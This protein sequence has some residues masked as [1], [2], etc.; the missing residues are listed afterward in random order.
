[1]AKLTAPTS[2]TI[3]KLCVDPASLSVSNPGPTISWSGTT[4]SDIDHYNFYIKDGNSYK[5]IGNCIT[6]NTSDSTTMYALSIQRDTNF[7]TYININNYNSTFD[8]YMRAIVEE[9]A[10]NPNSSDMSTV[11]VT[12]RVNEKPSIELYQI[13][14][15]PQS[16][17]APAT[18]AHNKQATNSSCLGYYAG[19]YPIFKINK[20]G[21]IKG[22]FE[23]DLSAY[24]TEFL[25]PT[26]GMETYNIDDLKITTL[27][28]GGIVD[29]SSVG[30]SANAALK[31]ILYDP[32]ISNK[33][34]DIKWRFRVRLYDGYEYSDNN[35]YWP[36]GDATGEN[37]WCCIPTYPQVADMQGIYNQHDDTQVSGTADKQIFRQVRIKFYKDTTIHK[38]ANVIAKIGSQRYN[39]NFD[40]NAGTT[41]LGGVSYIDIT[42]P[43]TVTLSG[44]E[45][46]SFIIQTQNSTQTV[47]KQFTVSGFTEVQTP[48]TPSVSLNKSEVRPFISADNAQN[49]TVTSTSC[50]DSSHTAANCAISF[51]ASGTSGV[52]ICI[53]TKN[54]NFTNEKVLGYYF[55][56]SWVKSFTPL[57]NL[58]SNILNFSKY[59]GIKNT[60]VYVRITNAFGTIIRSTPM[61]LALK[62][63]EFPTFGLNVDY[64]TSS[65][66]TYQTFSNSINANYYAQEGLYLNFKPQLTFSP[67]EKVKIKVGYWFGDDES[68]KQ[69]YIDG[70]GNSEFITT[71][72]NGWS[73]TPTS[74]LSTS[75]STFS[76]VFNYNRGSTQGVAI[77]PLATTSSL[78]WKVEATLDD[79][80]SQNYTVTASP[81]RQVA[82]TINFVNCEV[83][84]ESTIG[85]NFTVSDSG[86]DNTEGAIEYRLAYMDGDSEIT[87]STTITPPSG[88]ATF[89]SVFDWGEKPVYVQSVSYFSTG[90]SKIII[91]GDNSEKTYISSTLDVF[92]IEP[93]LAIRE[94]KLGVNVVPATNAIADLKAYGNDINHVY[95]RNATDSIIVDVN[96]A[97]PAITLPIYEKTETPTSDWTGYRGSTQLPTFRRMGNLVIFDW[98]CSPTSSGQINNSTV[99]SIPP[100]FTPVDNI[101]STGQGSNNGIFMQRANT[102][103]TIVVGRFRDF[104][105]TA[106]TSYISVP[107]NYWVPIHLVY[108]TTDAYPTNI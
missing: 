5:Y 70:S 101:A 11:S 107:T 69:Y 8:I 26:Q 79:D 84:G 48:L 65:S 103:G 56:N 106:A 45:S 102:S 57:Y 30:Y 94:N 96:T 44:G 13:A 21:T 72:S 63:R 83:T 53:N 58:S 27:P 67:F 39:C 4:G 100:G 77:G 12:I 55:N 38:I 87:S 15:Y 60:Y 81:L 73:A 92:N 99:C 88:S 66:G 64:A 85:Y 49:L 36:S 105:C 6:S 3:S 41:G 90:D 52:A 35:V 42:I 91:T 32:W 98:A 71:Y 68:T 80:I 33:S 18:W 104:S 9:G 37:K 97:L 23:F 47:N 10:S 20:P 51:P 86:Y 74:L 31:G 43:D 95:I 54:N 1:M 59:S 82:P 19:F 75:L 29:R 34:T 93:T 17:N 28:S 50:F 46:I 22:V 14:P 25:T 40:F 76:S 2:I 24:P 62:F 61:P 16:N 7:N 78:H 108:F 89:N